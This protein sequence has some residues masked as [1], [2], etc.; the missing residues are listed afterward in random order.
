MITS[1]APRS[2]R[3]VDRHQVP[4]NLGL[5]LGNY[6]QIA[7]SNE[8]SFFL[9]FMM[10]KWVSPKPQWLQPT[11]KQVHTPW[12]GIFATQINL[13]S[14]LQFYSQ[15]ISNCFLFQRQQ[16]DWTQ[17]SDNRIT[18]EDNRV[19]CIFFL[20]YGRRKDIECFHYEEM[21]NTWGY[22]HICSDWT[23][24]SIHIL[25]TSYDNCKFVQF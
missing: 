5:Y 9:S 7:T 15:L 22:W 6:A 3:Q 8:I 19:L 12:K 23:L 16:D 10:I 1:E 20:E 2:I 4:R 17:L 21:L 25:E 14:L 11:L 18:T 13:I 24:H